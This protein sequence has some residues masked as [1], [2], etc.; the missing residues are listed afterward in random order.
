MSVTHVDTVADAVVAALRRPGARGPLNVADANPVRPRDLLMAAFP[1]MG[2]PTRI[3]TMP[4]AIAWPVAHALELTWRF[5]RRHSAPPLTTYAVA[6]L[7]WPFILDLG[8]LET[9]LGL[10]SL[11]DYRDHLAG[12]SAPRG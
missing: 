6:H 5:A 1:A 4:L 10:R 8:R 3:S 7:A 12:L 11:R 2:L 9:T